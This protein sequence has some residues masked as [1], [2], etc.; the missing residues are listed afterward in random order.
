M[1]WDGK[2]TIFR[3][4][5]W[6]FMVLGCSRVWASLAHKDVK[7]LDDATVNKRVFARL[8][9]SP[10]PISISRSTI[11]QANSEKSSRAVCELSRRS[12]Q[13][14]SG[15]ASQ[16]SRGLIKTKAIK[17]RGESARYQWNAKGRRART[18]VTA[19]KLNVL[20]TNKQKRAMNTFEK[21]T[22]RDNGSTKEICW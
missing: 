6:Q 16:G 18:P 19:G 13:I 2:E 5:R 7:E 4:I 11:R 3:T 15:K 21:F 20:E 10:R 14:A 12:K 9:L 22:S 8:A 17:R 1:Q